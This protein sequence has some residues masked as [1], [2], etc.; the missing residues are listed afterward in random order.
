MVRVVHSGRSTCHAISGPRSHPNPQPPNQV[1]MVRNHAEFDKDLL[2]AKSNVLDF[3]MKAGGF[4][5]PISSEP[6]GSVV[7]KNSR[8]I[9]IQSS[10]Y[11]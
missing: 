9:E 2:W 10:G 4:G 1:V 8:E 3:A 11:L 6:P 5:L 7:C